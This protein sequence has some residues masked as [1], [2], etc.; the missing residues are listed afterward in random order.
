VAGRDHPNPALLALGRPGTFSSKTPTLQRAFDELT[1]APPC[2]R[3][4]II[5]KRRR[6]ILANTYANRC[7]AE[8]QSEGEG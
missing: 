5:E 4:R 2:R 7:A 1:A 6:R 8:T 3:L